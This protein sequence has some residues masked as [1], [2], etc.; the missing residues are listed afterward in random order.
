[1]VQ[2]SPV[3]RLDFY[4]LSREKQERFLESTRGSAPPA[5]IV[6]IV[7]DEKRGIMWAAGAGAALLAL[8][9]LYSMKFG[10]LGASLA[11]HGAHFLVLYAGLLFAIPYC[12]LRAAAA[13]LGKKILPFKPGIYVFPM[14]AVDARD[15]VLKIFA[16]TDI[17]NVG[18]ATAGGALRLSFKG[19]GA[20]AFPAKEAHDAD[21]L[22]LVVENAQEQVKHALASG[23]DSELTTLDPFYEA[24]KSWTSPIGPKEPLAD[25]AP[26]WRKF[27]YAIAAAVALTLGPMLWFVHNKSSDDS[28][29]KKAVAQNTP[30]SF[31]SYLSVG[32]RHTDEVGGTLLPRAELTRAKTAQTVEAVQTF[33]DAHPKSAI[34]AEA[35]D[36]LREAL[37]R[38]LDKAKKGASLAS[39]AAFQKKYPNNGLAKEIA[40]AKHD[41]YVAS[42]NRFKATAPSDDPQLLAFVTRLSKWLEAKGPEMTIV[43]HR[44]VS[45]KALEQADKFM[46][47]SSSNRAFGPHQ[48][49]KYFPETGD[50]PKEADVAVAFDKA[51]KKIFSPDLIE[52]KMGPNNPDEAAQTALGAKQPLVSVRY[53]FGWLGVVQGSIQLKR[54]FAGVHVSGDAVFTLPDGGAERKIKLD[55]PS[56]RGLLMKYEAQHDGLSAPPADDTNAEPG[57]YLAEDLRALDHIAG[58]LESTFI[59]KEK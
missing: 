2:S 19:G 59:K 30:E 57:V 46:A 39:L 45:G 34:D 36:A 37:L 42:I 20:F 33:L 55:V 11:V 52:V 54:A 27:D 6:Q 4:K 56:S 29:L 14:C 25:R 12:G 32:K 49:T 13:F 10:V 41:F 5:S 47:G 1:M 58:I 17:A 3:R 40:A 9:I 8:I 15:K 22:N 44:E 38:E 21:S 18:K 35:Q 31:Q 16:M 26:P 43:F 51:M 50:Q 53:R 24:R 7:G 28:M 48:V 23:D